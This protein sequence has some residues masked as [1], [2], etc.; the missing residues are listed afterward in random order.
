MAVQLDN[1]LG[2]MEFDGLISGTIPQVQVGGGVIAK[3]GTKA[4][5]T[6]G[7]VLAKGGDGKLIVL[8]SDVDD[9]GTWSGTGNGS[10]TK[11]NLMSGGVAPAVLTEVK[12]GGAETDAYTYNAVTGELEFTTAPANA[13]A[14]AIKYSTGGG[15]ADCILCDDIEVGTT[16]DETV[17]VYTAGCFDPEHLIVAE[18]YTLTAADID[19]LRIRGIV[20]KDK[21]NY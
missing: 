18:D 1:K 19:A 15:G 8:G 17:A 13:A 6:R 5:L 2:T 3:L 9:T 7:T 12:V 20:L 21:A 10:T 11:F 4:T 14:I 16:A